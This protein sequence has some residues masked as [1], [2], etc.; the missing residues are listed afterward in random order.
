MSAPAAPATNQKASSSSAAAAAV[1][2]AAAAAAAIA[3]ARTRKVV[4]HIQ[5]SPGLTAQP[6]LAARLA[7]LIQRIPTRERLQKTAFWSHLYIKTIILP[8]QAWDKHRENSKK[9]A[10]FRTDSCRFM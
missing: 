6:P 2:A 3:T 7:H 4:V 10:V 9:V 8:R 5:H 1:A